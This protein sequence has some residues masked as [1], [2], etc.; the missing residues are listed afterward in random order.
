VKIFDGISIKNNYHRTYWNVIYRN[1]RD[2]SEDLC[3]S[4]LENGNM[5]SIPIVS[6]QEFVKYRTF[7]ELLKLSC[8]LLD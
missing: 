3:N 1:Y 7:R 5:L 6:T 2:L 8:Q 4:F